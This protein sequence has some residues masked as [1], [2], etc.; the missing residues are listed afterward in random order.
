MTGRQ[1]SLMQ[2]VIKRQ[3]NLMKVKKII[4]KIKF[5]NKYLAKII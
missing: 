1:S 4:S 2:R 5:K 3:K